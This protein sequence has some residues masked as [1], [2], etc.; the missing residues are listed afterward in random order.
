MVTIKK[1]KIIVFD[2]DGTLVDSEKEIVDAYNE[3]FIKNNLYRVPARMIKRHLGKFRET[4]IHKIYPS[5]GQRKIKK[6]A[7]DQ[8]RLLDITKAKANVEIILSAGSIGTPHIL[9]A[10]GVGPGDLLKKNNMI[11]IINQGELAL[12]YLATFI[13]LFIHGNKKASIETMLFKKEFF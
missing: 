3:S 4:I 5:L 12:L 7:E 6:I 2:F 11:P 8:S 10:S 9:Q 13:I 1:K